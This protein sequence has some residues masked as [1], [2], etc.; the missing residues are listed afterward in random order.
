MNTKSRRELYKQEMN[1]RHKE[2]YANKNDSGRFRDFFEPDK[3]SDVNFWKCKED[4]HELY[5]VPYIVGEQHP[6]LKPGKIDFLLDVFVHTKVG[7]NEDNFICLNRTYREKCPICEH[8]A[9]LKDSDE[10]DEV[11]IKAL[12]PTRRNIFNIVCMD[13]TKEEEKGIQVWNVS[14]WLFTNPLEELA[15]KKRGG[16]EIAYADIDEGKIISFRKKGSGMTTTEYT[17]FEFKDR[18]E[19]PDEILDTAV[20]LD[21]LIHKPT[22]DEVSEAY[23][24]T[25]DEDAVPE[26][27]EKKPAP[28]VARTLSKPA[29]PAAA[30]APAP[31][32]EKKILMKKKAPEPEPEPEQDVP[33]GI[34]DLEC[35]GGADFGKDYNE[36]EECRTC[37]VREQC[38]A[39]KEE[40]ETP[41]S[42]PEPEKP[43][44]KV[45][46]RRGK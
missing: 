1:S 40:L 5:I 6:R 21:E 3:K 13:S 35:P 17:A 2:N 32:P 23:F 11:A 16:G 39:K 45:L 46:S 29:A 30:P 41:E 27:E 4:D 34:E 15:H 20:C 28:T 9:E 38:A 12:N 19:I 22:Y 42:A 18:G 37:E 14:Q 8:Q 10:P 33:S 26:R 24:Q 31:A 36:Y 7:I 25:K 43:A 44:K